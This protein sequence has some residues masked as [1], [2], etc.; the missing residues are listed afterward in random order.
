MFSF[1]LGRTNSSPFCGSRSV[2]VHWQQ[3][4][5]IGELDPIAVRDNSAKF[6]TANRFF[7]AI[8]RSSHIRGTCCRVGFS[9]ISLSP[10]FISTGHPELTISSPSSCSRENRIRRSTSC[11]LLDCILFLSH[12]FHQ[13]SA[14]DWPPVNCIAS[15]T[16]VCCTHRHRMVFGRSAAVVQTCA[17]HLSFSR[18]IRRFS[19][20]TGHFLKYV[21][22]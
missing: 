18:Q 9:L 15:C 11:S 1:G 10:P 5:A 4:T 12:I 6:P 14:A 20:H 7:S 2:V 3:F 17:S 19:N 13:S 8:Q 16:G 22:W 21:G